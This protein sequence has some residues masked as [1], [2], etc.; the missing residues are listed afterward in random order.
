LSH[1]GNLFCQLRTT[2]PPRSIG[3]RFEVEPANHNIIILPCASAVLCCRL[4]C[5]TEIQFAG[6]V[7]VFRLGHAALC[8]MSRDR[9]PFSTRVQTF[10]R[11]FV[12]DFVSLCC[13]QR[14]Y[15]FIVKSATRALQCWDI[16]HYEL[17]SGSPHMP[18]EFIPLNK[19]GFRA[20]QAKKSS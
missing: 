4:K 8:R 16:D 17:P 3:T 19:T 9:L 15:F 7:P 10:D 6:A 11:A 2:R 5:Q 14:I 13:G 1:F 20:S 18:R 12:H